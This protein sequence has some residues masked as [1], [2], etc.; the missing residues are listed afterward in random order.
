MS[1]EL[2]DLP[3]ISL[4]GF[5]IDWACTEYE[6]GPPVD[7][8]PG[9]KLTGQWKQHAFHCEVLGRYYHDYL[10]TH[11]FVQVWDY[12]QQ[13]DPNQRWQYMLFLHRPAYEPVSGE[14]GEWAWALY[15]EYPA[16]E[17][18]KWH[19]PTFAQVG[20]DVDRWRS[21]PDALRFLIQ[22]DEH[23]EGKP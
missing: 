1:D 6:W 7:Y 2:P 13:D 14:R 18:D 4:D 3:P 15:H 10:G 20:E 11:L 12:R 16:I 5:A 8:P 21:T 17:G 23:P 9:A 19:M 22:G